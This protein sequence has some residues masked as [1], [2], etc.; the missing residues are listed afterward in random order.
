[1][2]I[3]IFY[4]TSCFRIK[5]NKLTVPGSCPGLFGV[6]IVSRKDGRK[7]YDPLLFARR[8]R[9]GQF[10]CPGPVEHSTRSSVLCF[11]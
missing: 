3:R 6:R 5:F 9:I 1:M 10:A 2:R 11:S 7:N 4:A 8:V